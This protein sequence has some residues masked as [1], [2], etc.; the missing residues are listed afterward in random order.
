VPPAQPYLAACM[1]YSNHASYMREWI[2]FHRLMGFERFFLYDN[3]STDDHEQV[4]RPY[5]EE[6]LVVMH[7]R[8]G[9]AE[10][11]PSF[12]HCLQEH[13]EDARWIAFIDIDEFLF[14]PRGRL[15]PDV[16]KDYEEFPAVG[17]NQA[18]FG[19]GGHE[20]RPPGLVIES[21]LYRS[22]NPEVRMVKNIV[23]PRRTSD[24]MNAHVFVHTDGERV[25]VLKRPFRGRDSEDV[26]F[27]R[28]RINHYYTKS[29][30]E[31][32]E[33]WS[34]AEADTGNMRDPK[35]FEEHLRHESRFVRDEVILQ[36]VPTLKAALA[37]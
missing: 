30:E 31:M 21:Y 13:R 28:L 7:S 8:P 17:V 14:S 6:G 2:E 34:L 12:R 3:G 18:L 10:Q 25:D 4:L 33:K 9:A 24:V 26:R 32:A 29:Q 11:Y 36:Y 37:S 22:G 23:D 1:T 5:V 20:R 27:S 15:V 16:L 35:H 19:T